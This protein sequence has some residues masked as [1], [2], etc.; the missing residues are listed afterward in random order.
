MLRNT[1]ARNLRNKRKEK[2]EVQYILTVELGFEDKDDTQL[3]P[4]YVGKDEIFLCLSGEHILVLNASDRER[5]DIFIMT[6]FPFN[7]NL[8]KIN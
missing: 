6:T 4:C 8:P 7:S 1:K 5:Q 3:S 2:P